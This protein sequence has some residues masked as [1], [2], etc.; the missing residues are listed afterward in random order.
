VEPE[1]VVDVDVDVDGGRMLI[2]VAVTVP[3]EPVLPRTVTHWSTARADEVADP[4]WVK[5]V[6]DDVVTVIEAVGRVVV[7]VDLAEEPEVGR[8]KPPV[9]I[10]PVMSNPEL[11]TD[12]TLPKAMV[13]LVGVPVLLGNV[14]PP[15]MV[16]PRGKPPPAPPANRPNPPP[17]P[18]VV[19]G[20]VGVQVLLVE[21][22]MV[23]VVAV[24]ESDP[25]PGDP[26]EETQSPTATAE[27]LSSVVCVKVVEEVQSTVTCPLSGF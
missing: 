10:V 12:V 23:T 11:D 27:R 17:P 8:V 20:V 25:E 13:N 21:G 15:G 9:R 22:E 6:V 16:P 24:S 4:V 5:V 2:A 26:T 14:P 1:A 19:V 7:V 3:V 18:A